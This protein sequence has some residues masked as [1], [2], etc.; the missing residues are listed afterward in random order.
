MNGFRSVESNPIAGR[1]MISPSEK[2]NLENYLRKLKV[3][4]N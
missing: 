3:P 4:S 2:F 1:L